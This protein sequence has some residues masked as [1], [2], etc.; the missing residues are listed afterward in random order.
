MHPAIKQLAD[1]F[2]VSFADRSC[3][4]SHIFDGK[5]IAIRASRGK[6]LDHDL[7]HEVAHFAVASSMQ[8][9]MPEYGLGYSASGGENPCDPVIAHEIAEVQEMMC[10][11]L[12]VHW[13]TLYGID[14]A[15]YEQT[16]EEHE[17]KFSTWDEYLSFKI[18]QYYE[19][20]EKNGVRWVQQAWEALF[21]LDAAGWL[22]RSPRKE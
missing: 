12:C 19:T 9:K 22:G 10:H 11:F 15:L 18:G 7:L 3:V 1:H 16:R 5:T 21:I 2:S 13:G 20:D 14:P 6:F 17:K 4:G 8:R